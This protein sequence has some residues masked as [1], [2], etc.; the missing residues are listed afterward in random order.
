MTALADIFRQHGPAYREQFGQRI[1][2][3]HLAAMRD[4]E[5]CRTAALG[6]QVYVCPDCQEV[7]YRYHSC[8]NRHCP[9]CQ[10][11][12][13]EEWLATQQALLLPV[14]YFMLTFTLPQALRTLARSQQ[15]FFYHTLFQTSA[16]ATKKL[17]AD[18]R[19]IGGQ[20][21][22]I[23]VLHTWGRDLCYHPHVHYLVPCGGL[24]ADGTAWL[25]GNPDFLLPVKALGRIFRAKFRTALSK[26]EC[27]DQIPDTV[28]QQ[29]WVVHAKPVG[30]G[31]TALKYLA[32]Y[33]FRVAI[34]NQRI[35]KLENGQVTFRY[36]D[37]RT[38]KRKRRT[39]AAQEF[40]RRFLQHILPKGFVKVRYYG[41]FSPS[42]RARLPL[43]QQQL[44]LLALPG[45]QP[46]PLDAHQA[47]TT[48]TDY[49]MVCCPACGR[50]LEPQALSRPRNRSP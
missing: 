49:R 17:A 41:I 2:G 48:A 44:T 34:S 31:R 35:L 43:L 1:P 37:T 3:S 38:G 11:G 7:I 45:Y 20:I 13:A 14:P 32:V 5:R 36:Q 28:W 39:V 8:R 23:G 10:N 27:F 9:T 6:G 24:N 21:G 18:P 47:Q 42:W 33:V 12:Q 16:A 40:I 19:F 15:K 22:M 30:D 50:V 26:T 25:P 29:D 46:L 4:I